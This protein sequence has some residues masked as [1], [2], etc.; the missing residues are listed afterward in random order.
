MIPALVAGSAATGALT[1]AF[2]ASLRAPHG[3][4]WGPR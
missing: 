1:A 3:G 4:L 2:G